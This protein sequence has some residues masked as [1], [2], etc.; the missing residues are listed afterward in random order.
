[1]Y[2]YISCIA[3]FASFFI[4]YGI[5]ECENSVKTG[6]KNEK[7]AISLRAAIFSKGCENAGALPFPPPF[8]FS[9]NWVL[10]CPQ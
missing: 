7:G 5:C 9:E 8:P 4:Y 2:F 6:K 10:A 3:N 1:M